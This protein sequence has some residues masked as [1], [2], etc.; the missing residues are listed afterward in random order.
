MVYHDRGKNLPFD[1][2]APNREVEGG[3]QKK[4]GASR[5]SEQ[6]MARAPLGRTPENG[7]HVKVGGNFNWKRQVCRLEHLSGL[8]AQGEIKQ[9]AKRPAW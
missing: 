3:R 2:S 4:L 5:D 1:K 8:E 6:S 9:E 7:R